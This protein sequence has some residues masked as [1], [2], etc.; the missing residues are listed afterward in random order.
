M[1]DMTSKK[2]HGWDNNKENH[3]WHDNKE[4]SLLT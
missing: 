1:D 3:G 2:N 4:K